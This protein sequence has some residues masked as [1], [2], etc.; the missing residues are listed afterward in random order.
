[1]LPREEYPGGS[2][3]DAMPTGERVVLFHGSHL[4]TH[5]G[6]VAFPPGES[7]G[8]MFNRVAPGR[9]FAGLKHDGGGLAENVDGEWHDVPGPYAGTSPLIY[10]L[11]GQLIHDP[12]VYPDGSV[13]SQGYGYI[14]ENNQ[15]VA[16]QDTFA[17]PDGQINR[18]S[19][20]RGVI[21]G[22]GHEGGLVVR[23]PD[24]VTRLLAS[25]SPFDIR[26]QGVGPMVA[27]SFWDAQRD[28]LQA[29]VYVN[30]LAAF[31]S[32]P[33]IGAPAPPVDKPTP[34]PPT[35]PKPTMP[36][37][38]NVS[39]IVRQVLEDSTDVRPWVDGERQEITRRVVVK[40]G[41]FPFGMKDR[42]KDPNNNNNSD[43][44]LTY[45]LDPQAS[46]FEI[47][48]ILLGFETERPRGQFA[49]WDYKGTFA[50]GENGF[51]RRV[52]AGVPSVPPPSPSEPSTGSVG[53]A[54]DA[55]F[56]QLLNDI[57]ALTERVKAL[58]SKPAPAPNGATPLN[59]QTIA[60]RS[61]ATNRFVSADLARG[62][63]APLVA[64]RSD[65][66]EWELFT[67]VKP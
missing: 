25:E 44:A 17:T 67:I 18:Y 4:W 22:Q 37:A 57:H 6:P 45:A 24:G 58:E 59:G 64:D 55:K 61:K 36:Q 26:V 13:S 56:I 14:D 53:A 38:P 47:Y 20:Y 50:D 12:I 23:G 48:D 29:Y 21:F 3:P 39:A 34:P 33:P 40:L 31:L 66:G 32:L 1:M 19:V 11:N 27:V 46:R 7:F 42:D 65:I 10:N 52:D 16:A 5:A 15:P 41:G 28:G 30:T 51:F 35:P 54:L 2:H 9:K 49:N 60:L 8:T 62:E 43:D 63:Q